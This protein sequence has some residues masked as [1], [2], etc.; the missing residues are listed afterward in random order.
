MAR[1][2][3]LLRA[4][5]SFL[6]TLGMRRATD[7]PVDV[8][9]LSDG[10]VYVLRRDGQIARLLWDDDGTWDTE[11]RQTI[12][13]A[14]SADGQFTW[15]VAIIRD[16]RDNLF[17]SD[18]ALHRITALSRDG[19]FLA[20]WG[21]HGSADGQLDHPSHI[22][23][24]GAEDLFVSDALNHRVQKFTRDGG[25]LM[26]WGRHG[27]GEG[28]FDMPWGITVDDLWAM[29]TWGTGATTV[30]RSSRRTGRLSS[31]WGAPEAVRVSSTGPAA[32]PWTPTG[33]SMS[34][35]PETTES[36]SLTPRGATWRSSSATPR[37]PRWAET[38]C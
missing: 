3:G 11:D 18:E 28:E 33:T 35:T 25:F 8:C 7:Y 31:N 22:A 37:F 1:P 16:S 12:G 19:Q 17:I 30:C 4:G 38:I 27:A 20:S 34:P 14:G 5:F 13:G 6:K 10:M 21:E 32:W 24:D 26:S 15:P 2:Y 9:V 36:N 23:F 29:S